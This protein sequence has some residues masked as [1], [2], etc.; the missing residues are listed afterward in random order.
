MGKT[1]CSVFW[2]IL[3][4]ARME[5]VPHTVKEWKTGENFNL[6]GP[7]AFAKRCQQ[8]DAV[9]FSFLLFYFSAGAPKTPSSLN[10]PVQGFS[11]KNVRSEK[12]RLVSSNH[13][14]LVIILYCISYMNYHFHA[15]FFSVRTETYSRAS[16][17][18]CGFLPCYHA[19]KFHPVERIATR[20]MLHSKRLF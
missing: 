13:D 10:K 9:F 1:L 19:I 17:C 4:P 20:S 2:Q 11:R 5:I 6:D 14:W 8:E 16:V 7:R 15:R 18:C 12:K 3:W